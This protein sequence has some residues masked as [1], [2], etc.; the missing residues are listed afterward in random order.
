[1]LFKKKIHLKE[2]ET[3]KER[4]RET[5]DEIETDHVSTYI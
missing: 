4:E 3:D 2:R 1:M 5:K